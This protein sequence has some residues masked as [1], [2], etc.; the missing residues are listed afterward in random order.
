MDNI[1]Y[2]KK[3]IKYNKL[4][5]Q[6]YLE[7][8]RIVGS[9]SG[10]FSDSEVPLL[11][12]RAS[13]NLFCADFKATNLARADVSA[14]AKLENVGIGIK[15]FIEGNKKTLQKVAEFNGQQ[16]LYKNLDTLEKIKKIA[17]LRN[18][19]I[20]FTKSAYGIN[21]MIYHCIVRNKKGFWLFEETMKEI[22]INTIELLSEN[23]HTLIF[24]D[25]NE[26]YKFD[27]SKSTLYKRFVTEEYF[28]FVPVDILKDPIEELRKLKYTNNDVGI[29]IPESVVLPL[30]SAQTSGKKV[31]Y[32]K[33]GLNQWNAGGRTRKPDE[34]YIPIPAYVRE[35]TEN[36][37][38]RRDE[39]F[40]VTLP[41][42]TTIS[43]K[44]C[45]EDGKALMSNPN[46]ALGKWI[47]RD[48]LKIPKGTI[49]TY[50]TLL[51]IG[52]DSVCF[53]KVGNSYKM[54]FRP[55]GTFEEFLDKESG[56][57]FFE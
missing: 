22:D 2:D 4:E 28:A 25:C 41:D 31:V 49:V 10:L 18:K 16:G 13:E 44:V 27:E 32:P 24:K 33:S 43:M 9:L 8:L 1:N 42:N 34:V 21:N 51:E 35:L 55:I 39:S 6:K 17:E 19:R 53:Q 37:F 30:Y 29:M 47:L 45:Q 7:D 52:I 36:F 12:Y 48:V 15:T 56:N 11:H 5:L 14:D 20:N 38:P 46:T 40:N 3:C 54:D 23:Q 26:E 57:N 50:K